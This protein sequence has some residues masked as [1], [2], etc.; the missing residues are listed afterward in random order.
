MKSRAS[1]KQTLSLLALASVALT[2]VMLLPTLFRSETAL[3]IRASRQGAM[4]PDGFYVWQR[5]NAE[6]IHI[7]SITPDKN[8]LVITFDSQEQSSAAEKVLRRLLPENLDIAHSEQNADWVSRIG[9]RRQS[10]G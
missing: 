5:L 9:Q 8:S 7:K 4:L 3:Q 6:G 10:I 1:L 2:A